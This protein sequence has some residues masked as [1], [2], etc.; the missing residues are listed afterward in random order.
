MAVPNAEKANSPATHRFPPRNEVTEA[1]TNKAAA[2]VPRLFELSRAMWS[3]RLRP[4]GIRGC[5]PTVSDD[6]G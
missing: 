2:A 6:V 4:A 1:T 5:M 3:S